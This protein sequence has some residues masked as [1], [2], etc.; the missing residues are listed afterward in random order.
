MRGFLNEP[1][2][3]DFGY[4]YSKE[5]WGKGLGFE[6]AKEVLEH[7]YSKLR[8]EKVLGR[9]AEQNLGSIRILEKLGFKFQEKFLFNNTKASKYFY[10]GVS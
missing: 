7:G 10:A 9:T 2:G 8:L 1:H 4:R 6:A 5:S 3:I